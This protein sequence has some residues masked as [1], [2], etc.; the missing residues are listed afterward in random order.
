MDAVVINENPLHLEIC[1]LT[2]FLIFKFNKGILKAVASALVPDNFAGQD[3]TESA[4][5]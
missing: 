5:Y 3:L 2:V 1:L 4:E